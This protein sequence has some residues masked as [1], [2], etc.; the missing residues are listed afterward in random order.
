NP[1]GRG[2]KFPKS[3]PKKSLHG[4]L[5]RLLFAAFPRGFGLVW[6]F[7]CFFDLFRL[8]SVV[9]LGGSGLPSGF[10]LILGAV[11]LLQLLGR[12]LLRPVPA[13]GVGHPEPRVDA[14]LHVVLG[15][16]EKGG[17]GGFGDTPR[18]LGPFPRDLGTPRGGFGTHPE[19]FGDTPDGFRD[20]PEGFGTPPEGFGTP[21]EGFGTPPEGFGTLPEGF[22]DT[23]EGGVKAPQSEVRHPKVG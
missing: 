16:L 12:A 23:P 22:G 10:G 11:L 8:F 1:P 18:G 5:P 15:L 14:A 9:F 2:P 20:T 4:P 6:V 13:L 21:P 7:C 19:G 3:F 17:A